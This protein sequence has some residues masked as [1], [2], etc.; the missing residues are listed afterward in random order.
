MQT[1]PDRTG[2]EKFKAIVAVEDVDQRKTDG[3]AEKTVDRMKHRVPGRKRSII[4]TDLSES[5]GGIDK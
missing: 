1:A 2:T 3:S 5:F 4:G